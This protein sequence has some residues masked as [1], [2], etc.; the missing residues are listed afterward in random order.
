MFIA[1]DAGG[2]PIRE[3]DLHSVVADDGCGL[4]ARLGL[5]HRQRRK[6]VGCGREGFFLPALVVTGGARTLLAQVGEVV[7][8]RVAIGPRDVDTGASLH[9]DFHSGRLPAWIEWN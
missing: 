2:V 9:V 1:I 3:A 7:V 4:R 8:A 5:E 6:G